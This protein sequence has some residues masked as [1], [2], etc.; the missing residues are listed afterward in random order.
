MEKVSIHSMCKKIQENKSINM[1]E[2]KASHRQ[3]ICEYY[4]LVT[5]VP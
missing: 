4:P 3:K 2:Q 1:K 5:H